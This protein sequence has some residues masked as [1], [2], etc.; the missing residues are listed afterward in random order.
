MLFVRKPEGK[1]DLGV[2]WKIILKWFLG[3]TS[4]GLCDHGNEPSGTI[5]P[6]WLLA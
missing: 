6:A 5:R 1:E 2:D 4:G 3:G